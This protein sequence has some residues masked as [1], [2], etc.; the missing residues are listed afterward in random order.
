M[1]LC[2]SLIAQNIEPL[3][4]EGTVSGTVQ[5][6]TSKSNVEF[7]TV[8]LHTSS[9]SSLITGAITDIQGRFTIPNVPLGSYYAKV[10]FIG[11]NY[12]FIDGIQITKEAPHYTIPPISL[13]RSSQGLDE[14]TVVAEKELVEIRIDKTVYNVSKDPASQGGTGLDV[15]RNIPSVDVDE[16]DIISLRNDNSVQI[17]IDGRPSAI[18]AAQLLKQMPATLIEK[19]EVITNPS[20]KYD[21]E[22]MSGIINVILKKEKAKGVNGT[23]SLSIGYGNVEKHNASFNINFRKRK[24]NVWLGTGTNKWSGQN[25]SEFLRTYDLADS[26]FYQNFYTD[27]NYEM[28][29]HWVGSGIDYTLNKKNTLYIWGSAWFGWNGSTNDYKYE[30]E[31]IS[32]TP[33]SYSN[34]TDVWKRPNSG[35]NSGAGWQKEFDTTGNH[36]LDIDV[37]LKFWEDRTKSAFNEDFFLA[38]GDVNGVSTM[39]NTDEIS[40]RYVLTTTID[41][42]LP[43]NDSFKLEAGFKSNMDAFYDS[44]YSESNVSGVLA[45]DQG[46]NTSFVHGQDVY[47]AYFTLGRQFKKIGAQIG[48]RVEHVVQEFGITQPNAVYDKTYTSLFPSL[49]LTYLVKE[50]N[51]FKL[52]YSRRINKPIYWELRP[53]TNYSDPF[54]FYYGNPDLNPEYINV[55]EFG[56]VFQGKKMTLTPGFYYR[57]ITDKKIWVGTVASTGVVTNII[58]NLGEMDM[59]GGDINLRYNP[60]KMW[61]INATF[62]GYHRTISNITTP[63]TIQA[64]NYGWD[65]DLTTTAM[66]KKSWTIQ[67][68][69][70]FDARDVGLQGIE[71]PQYFITLSIMKKVWQG[72]GNISLKFSDLINT[73]VYRFEP[74]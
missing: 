57:Q 11:Y 45:P 49:Y 73:K 55:Y 14:L 36:T 66:L 24:T 62:N 42:E 56:Y 33:I 60:S 34:R 3:T 38:N 41:Y 12:I 58:E 71:L 64:R 44:F 28:R 4:G 40:S 19:I 54:R 7:A 43:I 9:D 13:K 16:A 17:L 22:G 30:Y 23:V 15:L 21:A 61:R 1:G 69:Q 26:L 31:D 72:A 37:N 48:T 2:S 53:L 65:M 10:G 52:S 6:G 18:P 29:S 8:S 20:A 46:L 39:Q 50:K 68:R 27:N 70:Q 63:G 5:D 74:T 67:L 35:F 59:V 51:T 47:A 32:H 25:S